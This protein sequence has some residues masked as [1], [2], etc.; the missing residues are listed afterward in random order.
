M[1]CKIFED[2]FY[3]YKD[4]TYATLYDHPDKYTERYKGLQTPLI[5]SSYSH[6]RFV[7]SS[8]GTFGGR[9]SAF[10]NDK[11]IHMNDLGDH[12]KFL[13]LAQRNRSIISPVPGFATHCINGFLAPYRDWSRIQ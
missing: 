3:H 5:M 8:C 12:N 6:W 13:K 11:E 1:A 2:V 4:L 9:I 10:L 7:P